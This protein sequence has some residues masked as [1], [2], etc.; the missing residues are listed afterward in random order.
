MN[1]VQNIPWK[2]ISVEAVAIVASILL[3]F[4]ID[5]WW[6]E[7][8]S[9]RHLNNAYSAI[10]DDFRRSKERVAFYRARAQARSDAIIKLYNL[11]NEGA[12]TISAEELDQALSGLQWSV[13]ESVVQ[14]P[15]IQGHIKGAEVIF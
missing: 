9:I 6:E 4:S 2:R 10:L 8:R 15:G 1:R 5:A 7:R 12:G 14:L 11:A 3:A 13:T